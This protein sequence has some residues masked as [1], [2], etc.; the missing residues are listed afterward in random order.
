MRRRVSGM[1]GALYGPDV[2][3]PD[4]TVVPGEALDVDRILDAYIRAEP[5]QRR[6]FLCRVAHSLT[7]SI[8]AILIDRPDIDDADLDRLWDINEALHQLTSCVNPEHPW[9]V[10]DSTALLRSI[11]TDSF[12]RGTD[13]SIGQALAAAATT[14]DLR[15]SVAAK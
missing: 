3:Y 11:I 6:A 4:G 10:P 5:E 12:T 7:A 15:K 9:S 1:T 14:F 8:R 2:Q 13:R